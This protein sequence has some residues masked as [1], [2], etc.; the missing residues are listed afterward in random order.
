MVLEVCDL[1][2]SSQA[3]GPA[4]GV[5]DA[6]HV[7]LIGLARSA[8]EELER[9][10]PVYVLDQQRTAAVALVVMSRVGDGG[11][12][13]QRLVNSPLLNASTRPVSQRSPMVDPNRVAGDTNDAHSGWDAAIAGPLRRRPP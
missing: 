6:Q 8:R 3:P 9:G 2:G 4:L 13:A 5:R 7:E 12:H 1:D 10:N 11:G